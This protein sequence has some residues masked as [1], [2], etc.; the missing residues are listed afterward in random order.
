MRSWWLRGCGNGED[1]DDEFFRG[2]SHRLSRRLAP[3][4][5]TVTADASGGCVAR[6]IRAPGASGVEGLGIGAPEESSGRPVWPPGHRVVWESEEEEE[7]EEEEA[8]RQRQC[9]KRQGKLKGK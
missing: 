4:S 8:K 5:P 9:F 1:E 7:E 2:F 6:V 3:P